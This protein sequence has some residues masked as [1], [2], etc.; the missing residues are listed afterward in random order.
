MNNEVLQ[1]TTGLDNL[2]N[3]GE[4]LLISFNDAL[5]NVIPTQFNLLE[6]H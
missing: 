4:D 2:S 6:I 5:V 3:V 1:S